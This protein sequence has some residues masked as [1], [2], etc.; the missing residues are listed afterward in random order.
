MIPISLALANLAPQTMPTGTLSVALFG[1]LAGSAGAICFAAGLAIALAFYGIASRG[2]GA[3][4]N[5]RSGTS[6]G[7]LH[8]AA[9]LPPAA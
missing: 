3:C 8:D 1:G 5:I 7:S 2:D 4:P 9:P 6:T